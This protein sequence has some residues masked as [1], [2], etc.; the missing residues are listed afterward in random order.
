[1]DKTKALKELELLKQKVK[2]LETVI[3][4]PSISAEQRM[5]EIWRSCNNVK[6]SLDN[7]RTYFKDNEP[8]FQQDWKNKKLY[9]RYLLIYKIFEDEFKISETKIDELVIT[10]LSK[11]LNCS[12]LEPGGWVGFG[13]VFLNK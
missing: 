4:T 12:S 5:E 2:D 3:N 9:Y 6:Y 11:D 8:M 1:M 13:F 10:T 7:C